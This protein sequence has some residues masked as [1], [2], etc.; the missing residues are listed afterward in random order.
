MD[1]YFKCYPISHFPFGNPLYYPPYFCE[2]APPPTYPFP[3]QGPGIPLHWNIKASQDQG[4]LCQTMPSS[5]T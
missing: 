2:D 1:L 5:P 4:L 3:V